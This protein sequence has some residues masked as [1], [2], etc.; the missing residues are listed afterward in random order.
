MEELI[1]W[2]DNDTS[3]CLRSAVKSTVTL[4][5]VLYTVFET[6]YQKQLRNSDDFFS[7]KELKETPFANMNLHV[8]WLG[9][10]SKRFVSSIRTSIHWLTSNTGTAWGRNVKSR[11]ETINWQIPQNLIQG[12]KE[13]IWSRKLT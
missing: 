6:R 12:T 13:T 1:P 3:R 8:K 4:I 11:S 7:F 9:P 10:E 2:N 5:R